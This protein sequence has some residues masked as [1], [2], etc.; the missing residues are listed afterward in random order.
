MDL[1]AWFN[2]A[3]ELEERLGPCLEAR[4][5]YQHALHHQPADSDAATNLGLV[6]KAFG[7]VGASRAA[8]MHAQTT[9]P[10]LQPTQL[11]RL[12]EDS[13]PFG[14]ECAL[15]ELIR[16][17]ERLRVVLRSHSFDAASVRE[18]TDAPRL[19]SDVP[20]TGCF[21]RFE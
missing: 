11:L 13:P 12:L 8:H 3:C 2:Y 7:E 1:D 18:L 21:A 4:A 14:T 9:N 15:D 5:A 6:C 19:H 10:T 17:A 20:M 16:V